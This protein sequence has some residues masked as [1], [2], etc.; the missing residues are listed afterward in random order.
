MISSPEPDTYGRYAR[1]SLLADY[2]ELLALK[3]RTTRRAAVADFLA[4]A[5]WDLELIQSAEDSHTIDERLPGLAEQLDEA[6]EEADIVF[7]QMGERRDMLTDRYP[8][9]VTEDEVSCVP[10]LDPESSA[11]VAMLALTVAHA[12]G[13]TSP[14]PPEEL[15]EEIVA[16]I[17]RSR[18]L[19]STG[20]A[21][22][23]RKHVSFETALQAACDEIGFKAAPN[24]APRH[25]QAHDAGVDVLAHLAWDEDL[26]PGS[27][28]FIGQVTVGRSDSWERKI[29]EPSPRPWALRL[30]TV[31]PPQ[32]FLAVP[33]HVE[34]PM[35]EHLTCDGQAL[36]L[37]RL[38]LA[39]FKNATDV[40]E[41]EIIRAVVQEEIDPL[42]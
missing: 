31:I 16:E 3:G 1:A 17:L 37:D 27:W 12:F 33:H 20:L 24:A 34:R 40:G 36:V 2:M 18:G 15:F 22:H 26:R 19:A 10:S 30:G 11:Y 42:D 35:M 29:K 32:P 8:F 39:R 14:H 5:G 6:R 23:R 7:Q 28:G 4:D 41:R 21:T 25:R 38:R 9:M 13:V